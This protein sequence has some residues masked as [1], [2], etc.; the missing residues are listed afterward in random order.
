MTNITN[1]TDGQKLGYILGKISILRW[2]IDLLD[3]C[4]EPS[5]S[6]ILSLIEFKF[7]NSIQGFS[8]KEFNLPLLIPLEIN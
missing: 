2:S 8:Y 6:F 3:C 4:Q 7:N 1:L 5:D